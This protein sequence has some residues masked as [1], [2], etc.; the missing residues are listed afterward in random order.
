MPKLAV[1]PLIVDKNGK[2]TKHDAPFFAP[3]LASTDANNAADLLA[4]QT[5]MDVCGMS[6]EKAVQTC[7]SSPQLRSMLLRKR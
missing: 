6:F 2:N 1:E 3:M 5:A 4:A 7:V